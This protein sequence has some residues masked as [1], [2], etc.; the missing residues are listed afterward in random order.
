[1][2]LMENDLFLPALKEDMT[3]FFRQMADAGSQAKDNVFV[4]YHILFTMA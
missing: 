3:D 4:Q 1:M 2:L